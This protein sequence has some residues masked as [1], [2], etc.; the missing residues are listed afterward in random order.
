[1]RTRHSIR[2]QLAGMALT[3]M[4]AAPAHALD[5]VISQGGFSGGGAMTGALS[6]T[7]T[8]HDGILDASFDNITAFSLS[9]SGDSLVAPFTLGM[10]DLAGLGLIAL[11]L[12]RH[13]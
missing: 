13:A 12:R 10:A 3:A 11:A 4:L 5:D 8:D 6:G 7:D 2:P 9:F 1:M